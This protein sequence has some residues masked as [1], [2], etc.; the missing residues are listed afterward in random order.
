LAAV[1]FLEWKQAGF[2]DP[3]Y[4]C[5]L[6]QLRA[7]L[8]QVHGVRLFVILG[9]SRAEQGFRP[10]LLPVGRIGNPSNSCPAQN[11]PLVFNL[12]RGG[13]SP[14]LHLLTLQRLLADGIH[15]DCVLLEI[16]PPSLVGERCGVTIAKATLRDL[17]LLRRYPV[18]WKTYAYAARD[19]LLLWHKYRNEFLARCGPGWLSIPASTPGHCWDASGEWSAVSEGVSFQECRDLTADAHRRYYRKLQSFQ[20]SSEAD[21][22]LR[23][24]LELCRKEAISVV[25][26]LMPEAREFRSWYPSSTQER[27]SDY[28]AA[29]QQEYGHPLIDARCW[30]PDS[31]FC[32]GHHV[33]RHGAAKFTLR[34]GK[35]LLV[36]GEW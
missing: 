23:E 11:A 2:Y 33:L 35:Q 34:F 31:D 5:R 36:S 19:R 6:N 20:V 17:P 18:S 28:L 22:A 21:L 32:D 16:F 13:S 10:T 4:G 30:V 3:K 12:A 25:L 8:E 14:L 24:L 9:T 29:L 26:F 7:R 15:P 1:G 27:L